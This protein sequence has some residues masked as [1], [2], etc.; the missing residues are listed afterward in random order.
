MQTNNKY[1]Y[2]SFFILQS[3]KVVGLM[4]LQSRTQKFQDR[5]Y[6]YKQDYIQ[7]KQVQFERN[8]SRQNQNAHECT[9][10]LNNFNKTN[11]KH[12]STAQ[13]RVLKDSLSSMLALTLA[14]TLY[15]IFDLQLSKPCAVTLFL[16][17][18]RYFNHAVKANTN[19]PLQQSGQYI[20]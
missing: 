8:A 14:L 12:R 11:S 17:F 18:S 6:T 20:F 19:L 2:S 4:R 16:L 15:I 10:K 7:R 9:K 5:N 13:I 1:V 3:N